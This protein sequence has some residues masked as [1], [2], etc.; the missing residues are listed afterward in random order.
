M[1]K[2]VNPG[3]STRKLDTPNQKLAIFLIVLPSIALLIKFVVMAN[4]QAG[5][6]YGA[7]GE[8]YIAGVDGLLKDGF[9]AQTGVLSYWPAGYPI[10][11]WPLA[12]ISISNFVYFISFIQSVFFAYSTWHFTNQLSKSSLKQYAFISS[13]LISFN[14]TLSLSTLVIGYELLVASILLLVCSLI[15]KNGLE[16]TE[17][18]K[19]VV[20]IS[21]GVLL[22]LANFVQPR[23]ILIG[24]F[25]IL[26]WVLSLKGNAIRVKVAVVSM[27]VMLILPG[28]L[29]FRNAEAN[30][31]SAISTN[32]GVTMKLGAGELTNG[33][34]PHKGP[35]VECPTTAG[36]NAQVDNQIVKCVLSWYLN[37]PVKA[38]ELAVNKAIFYWSPWTGPLATG[39]MARNPW[40]KIAPSQNIAKNSDGNELIYG[41]FGKVA[42]FGW[43]L[44]Q[45]ALLVI[46][47]I[48]LRRRSEVGKF[49]STLVATPVILSCLISMATLG[50]H[51]MRVTTMTLSLFLQAVGFV[52]IRNRLSKAF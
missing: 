39:S 22:S 10:L 26:I 48:H 3:K 32:L 12:V 47:F 17:K 30:G 19:I 35:D 8:N 23:I 31:F 4:I 49:L 18:A 34:F 29:M 40:L 33:G 21:V 24:A 45:L 38:A 20:V 5:G 1:T 6:W 15:L 7:D 13:L 11:I 46:G 36:N 52:A 44:G 27:I 50:D 43:I 37:H 28:L 51:R 25:F 2:K 9:F 16:G 42:S 14:P 41:T